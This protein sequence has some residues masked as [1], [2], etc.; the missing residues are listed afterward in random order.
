MEH[1]EVRVDAVI[2]NDR[3]ELLLA[4]HEKNKKSYWV[5]PGGHLQF[6][7]TLDGAIR[8]ELREELGFEDVEVKELLFVDEFIDTSRH[9]VHIGFDVRVVEEFLANPG[10]IA[11]D[12]SIRDV[13][14]FSLAEIVNATGVFYPSKEFMIQLIENRTAVML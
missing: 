14:F 9:V 2:L 3:G 6:G 8:R 10:V 11:E 12:E 1:I 4:L 7:E 13:R 5:L